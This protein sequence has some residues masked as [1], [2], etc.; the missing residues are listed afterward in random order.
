MPCFS[1]IIWYYAL[2][3]KLK[4]KKK[5][6]NSKLDK[7][8]VGSSHAGVLLKEFALKILRNYQRKLRIWGKPLVE[9]LCR[10]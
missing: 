1:L 3:K 5:S 4:K 7:V 10:I 8:R 6:K 2:I 9:C